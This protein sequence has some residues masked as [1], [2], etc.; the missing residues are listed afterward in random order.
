M[1]FF[2]NLNMVQE[3]DREQ[4]AAFQAEM[5]EPKNQPV[6]AVPSADTADG[7]TAVPPSAEASKP[8]EKEKTQ[9][10]QAEEEKRKAHEEAEA[11]RKAEWEENQR[12]RKEKERLEWEKAIAM[13]NDALIATSVK[14]LGD[15]TERLTRRN[16]KLCVT[17]YVQTLCYEDM[18]FARLVMHPRKSMVN[19]FHYINRKAREYLE[20]E[21]KD[22][23]EKPMAGGYGGDV[24]DE[25]CYQWAEEYFRDLD[26]KEDKTDEDEKFVPRPYRGISSTPKKK[27]EKKK[28]QPVK[29]EKPKEP[30]Q[31][32]MDNQITLDSFLQPEKMAG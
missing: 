27:A 28:P 20:K 32:S 7:M 17:E 25:L 22:N 16:M 15:A 10:E 18:A 12:K 14:R 8:A 6:Q 19:C 2:S 24:P 21:M 4:A 23:D 29:K 30:E 13:D 3:S 11:K 9:P 5:P 1:G 26:V 31:L